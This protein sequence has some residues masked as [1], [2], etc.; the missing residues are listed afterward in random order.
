MARH[1]ARAPI[2]YRASTRFF[3]LV[4]HTSAGDAFQP[5]R[6]IVMYRVLAICF[7]VADSSGRRSELPA[8]AKLPKVFGQF[9]FDDATTSPHDRNKLCRVRYRSLVFATCACIRS[10]L[11]LTRTYNITSIHLIIRRC[12]MDF[13]FGWGRDYRRH[14]EFTRKGCSEEMQ[15]KFE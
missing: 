11:H 4:F 10:D 13:F 8:R 14:T 5:R 3:D 1:R 2:L 6:E 15:K 12:A 7:P 9:H